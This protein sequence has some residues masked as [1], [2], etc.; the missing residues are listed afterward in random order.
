MAILLILALV[1]V[2]TGPCLATDLCSSDTCSA[3]DS[4][5]LIQAKLH[6]HEVADEAGDN[7]KGTWKFKLR[8]QRYTYGWKD[9]TVEGFAGDT[10]SI[11]KKVDSFCGKWGLKRTY[12]KG[13]R[14]GAEVPTSCSNQEIFIDEQTFEPP[15][16]PEPSSDDECAAKG[17]WT[18]EVSY[19]R[20]KGR[21]TSTTVE[22]YADD[23]WSFAN[24]DDSV[25]AKWGLKRSW[26]H[27]SRSG[28]VAQ[29]TCA[30]Q[31]FQIKRQTFQPQAITTTITPKLIPYDMMTASMDSSI[32]RPNTERAPLTTSPISNTTKADNT[33]STTK[34]NKYKESWYKVDLAV[35]YTVHKVDL[36]NMDECC[37]EDSGI[38]VPNWMKDL[39]IMVD[40]KACRVGITVD[41]GQTAR[42]ECKE[43]LTGSSIK[44]VTPKNALLK[45]CGFAAYGTEVCPP[46]CSSC[47][48]AMLAK[49]ATCTACIDGY[50]LTPTGTCEECLPGCSS[51]SNS[52]ECDVCKEGYGH[53]EAEQC[54][55]CP[56][57]C[58]SCEHADGCDKCKAGFEINTEGECKSSGYVLGEVNTN[59]CPANTA[60]ITEESECK[61]AAEKYGLN[62][63]GRKDKYVLTWAERFG[64]SGCF[65][66][67]TKAYFNGKTAGKGQ[68]DSLPIC[69]EE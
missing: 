66:W 58:Q 69:S 61:T 17:N 29:M 16:M 19:S 10:W 65:K 27:G 48:E 2:S 3:T 68:V 47:S 50:R 60:K 45:V 37:G 18:F 62:F 15:S 25:C 21:W 39:K 8:G 41:M 64:P 34:L 36:T 46:G 42:L 53:H 54:S 56:E 35:P 22:G 55:P 9:S 40:S 63:D 59:T 31:N 32:G 5:S 52:E 6:V 14:S 67:A 24:K 43:P 1:S 26:L 38:K 13:S 57:N 28:D 49:C 30:N 20:Y 44:I 12:L 33:C 23:E 11:I 7:D 51:C 4:Q